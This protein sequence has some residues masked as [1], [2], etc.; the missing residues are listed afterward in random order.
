MH[1]TYVIQLTVTSVSF[2]DVQRSFGLDQNCKAPTAG[3]SLGSVCL[4]SYYS[5]HHRIGG[6]CIISLDSPLVQD[7]RVDDP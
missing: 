7:V 3:R 4:R 5:N 6:H 1:L 2:L